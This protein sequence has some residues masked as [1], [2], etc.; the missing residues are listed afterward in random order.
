MDFTKDIIFTNSVTYEPDP[1]LIFQTL[2]LLTKKKTVAISGPSGIGKTSLAIEV[3]QKFPRNVYWFNCT[4]QTSFQN[5]LE[6]FR[7]K[8]LAKIK[9]NDLLILD[10]L[11]KTD[12]LEEFHQ[13]LPRDACYLI[14]TTSEFKSIETI[15]LKMPLADKCALYFHKFA[16]KINNNKICQALIKKVSQK[17]P[18]E[19]SILASFIRALD[20]ICTEWLR[21][22]SLFFINDYLSDANHSNFIDTILMITH[23]ST[24]IFSKF[25]TKITELGNESDVL[26]KKSIFGADSNALNEL[27]KLSLIRETTDSSS[28]Y[29]HPVILEKIRNYRSF[30]TEFTHRCLEF[31]KKSDATDY[32]DKVLQ[33]KMRY[34]SNNFSGIGNVLFFYG[35]CCEKAQQFDRAIGLFEKCYALKFAPGDEDFSDAKAEVFDRIASCYMKLGKFKEAKELLAI[36]LHKARDDALNYYEAYFGVFYKVAECYAGLG[37]FKTALFEHESVLKIRLELFG[38]R[39]ELCAQSCKKIAQYYL[40][41]GYERMA[42]NFY[43]TASDIFISLGKDAG[44][45]IGFYD[46][47][48]EMYASV[49]KTELTHAYCSAILGLVKAFSGIGELERFEKAVERARLVLDRLRR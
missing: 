10:D 26:V 18:L 28:I 41:L 33:L 43:R 23:E 19:M 5:S 44:F 30:I 12:Y 11:H 22:D 13:N 6:K 21:E 47:I 1:K 32:F 14:T 25:F 49:G 20:E 48:L 17:T 39:H 24:D 15:T 34:D 37:D 38:E 40:L 27:S 8:F 16:N 2:S 9:E 35:Q 29:I 42:A 45:L 7:Q 46:E 31:A 3:A 36:V 4:N